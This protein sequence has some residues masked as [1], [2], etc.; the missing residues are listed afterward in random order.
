MVPVLLLK[1]TTAIVVSIGW[2]VLLLSVFSYIIAREQNA[3]PW[4]VI[5]EHLGIALV[6]IVITHFVGDWISSVFG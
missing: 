4:K 1:L 2:G 3:H 6:V 5:F